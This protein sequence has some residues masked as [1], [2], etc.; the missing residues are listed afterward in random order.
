M[1]TLTMIRNKAAIPDKK[2]CKR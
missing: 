2:P 1:K